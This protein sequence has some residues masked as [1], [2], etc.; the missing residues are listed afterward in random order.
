MIS[1]RVTSLMLAAALSVGLGCTDATGVRTGKLSILLTDAPGDVIAAV[2]TISEIYLQGGEGEEGGRITLMNTPVT[3]D[4]LTLVDQTMSLVD[5]AEIPAGTYP[6]LRFVVTGG[7]LEVETEDGSAF[8]A[9]SPD[10]AGL[11]PGVQVSGSLQMPSFAETGIK[12][13]LLNGGI[14]IGAGEKIL[15]VDFDVEK[16]FGQLAGDSGTWVMHPVLDATDVSAGMA[17]A[18]AP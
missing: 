3:V 5:E 17:G 12:V 6:Q 9:S 1:N 2:V 18:G 11:P 4:L 16:S 13:N 7:Y 15:L 14:T 8:Y 10:Y